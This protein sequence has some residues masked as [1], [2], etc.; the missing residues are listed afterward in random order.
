VGRTYAVAVRDRGKPLDVGTEQPDKHLRLGL[1]Q[2]REICRDMSDRAVVLADL[3]A[4][5]GLLCGRGVPVGR[6]RRS[7]L[8]RTAISW[9]L[10]QGRRVANLETVQA[11]PRE[12]GYRG[13]AAGCAQI[14]EGL[15]RDV[16]VGVPKQGVTVVGQGEQLR[17][18][19]AAPEMTVNLALRNLTYPARGDQRV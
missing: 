6:E 18:A 11:L 13:V 12:C 7:Q 16:V 15:D 3:D 19:T 14:A 2:L 17:G 9:H 8:R 10:C 1:A 4:G 5:S